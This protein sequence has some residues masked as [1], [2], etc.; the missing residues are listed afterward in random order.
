MEH[1]L[2]Q[3]MSQKNTDCNMKFIQNLIPLYSI[4]FWILGSVIAEQLGVPTSYIVRHAAF[5]YETQLRGIHQQLRLNTNTASI[6][7]RNSAK[8]PTSTKSTRPSKYRKYATYM[9]L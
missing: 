9:P 1:K 5:I 3:Y 2:W 6:S 8:S 4:C 7:S